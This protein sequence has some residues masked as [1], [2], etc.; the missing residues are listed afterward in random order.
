ML[1]L[2][3]LQSTHRAALVGFAP[4][5][6]GMTGLFFFIL[7]PLYRLPP[8][9]PLPYSA[10]SLL[11]GFCML[12]P[13]PSPPP[14]LGGTAGQS[15]TLPHGENRCASWEPSCLGRGRALR[16]GLPPGDPYRQF[17]PARS[18]FRVACLFALLLIGGMTGGGARPAPRAFGDRLS[19]AIAPEAADTWRLDMK[20]LR[21]GPSPLRH[22]FHDFYVEKSVLKAPGWEGPLLL[23][24]LSPAPQDGKPAAGSGR[25]P[26]ASAATGPR[27]P[28]CHMLRF[29]AM[30]VGPRLLFP[31]STD[32]GPR[33]TKRPAFSRMIFLHFL[34]RRRIRRR[35]FP[36]FLP[37]LFFA[38]RDERTIAAPEAGAGLRPSGPSCPKRG[39]DLRWP[40]SCCSSG[41]WNAARVFRGGGGF[42]SGAENHTERTPPRLAPFV[43]T[44]SLTDTIYAQPRAWYPAGTLP[45]PPAS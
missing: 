3:R 24:S 9:L 34:G 4:A 11:N 12:C 30:S 28:P 15:R 20:T 29:P 5:R 14:P 35:Y 45:P 7:P 38:A 21:T 27:G 25:K 41:R 36:R 6:I 10:F 13:G 22:F 23:L 2:R 40:R 26:L 44:L 18:G 16:A 33:R 8:P 17:R 43:G 1:G 42:R 37:R 19:D 32:A 39:H 31:S